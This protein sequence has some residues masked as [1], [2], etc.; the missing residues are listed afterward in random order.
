MAHDGPVSRLVNRRLSRPLAGLAAETNL[1][2]NQATLISTGV[3]ALVPLLFAINHPRLAGIAIQAASVIDGVDGDL[4]RA[5]GRTT[6]FGAI[7]DAVSDR[8]A[9][10]A[11]LGGMTLWSARHERVRGVRLLGFAALIGS[12]M[13]SYSRART[14]AELRQE[15]PE[16]L[17]GNATR[18]VRL[19][20]AALGSVIKKPSLALALLALM[21][22]VSVAQRLAGLR[23]REQHHPAD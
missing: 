17:F 8:Y 14:E 2:P 13:V 10:A 5:T 16:E 9:D 21:T 6:R 18:D 1:T 19:L 12:L 15:L 23:R 11:I 7:L 22:N 3:A 4:A 20:I